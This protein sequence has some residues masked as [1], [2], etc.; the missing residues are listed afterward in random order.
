MPGAN[1]LTHE[2]AEKKMV[3]VARTLQNRSTLRPK[4]AR[5]IKSAASCCRAE[6]LNASQEPYVSFLRNVANTLGAN[7]V[8]LCVLALSQVGVGR[9]PQEDRDELI[10]R[11]MLRKDEVLFKSEGLL[12]LSARHPITPLKWTTQADPKL[13]QDVILDTYLRKS[14]ICTYP[15]DLLI[16]LIG[17]GGHEIQFKWES[18]PGRSCYRSERIGA[19]IKSFRLLLAEDVACRLQP[20][21][22]GM[23]PPYLNISLLT[24]I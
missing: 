10:S 5:T 13:S 15:S 20:T 14:F 12:R 1:R 6:K 9:M 21:V 11:L 8:L 19:A 7:F 23:L 18:A 16:S 22:T 24:N 17:D 4:E 2:D 3:S